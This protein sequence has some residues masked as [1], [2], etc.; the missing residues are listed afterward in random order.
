MSEKKL[1]SGPGPRM[2]SHP[3]LLKRRSADGRPEPCGR[4]HR[5]CALAYH[6][7][8]YRTEHQTISNVKPRIAYLLPDPLCSEAQID[9]SRPYRKT[10]WSA[11]RR[12]GSRW[13]R[14]PDIHNK[15]ISP[16]RVGRTTGPKDL[17]VRIKVSSK[18][19]LNC[20]VSQ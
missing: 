12:E 15:T 16:L 19:P 14:I 13:W 18:I 11:A 4:R 7:A 10:S 2:G 20:I 9:P 5:F 3:Q 17:I 6:K 8:D 1:P